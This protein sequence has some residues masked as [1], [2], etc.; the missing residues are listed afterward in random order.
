MLEALD[1]PYVQTLRAMGT[2]MRTIVPRYAVKNAMVPILSV[3]AFQLS[4]LIGA[5]FVVEQVFTVPG[6]GSQLIDAVGRKDIPVVQGITL[7][8]ALVVIGVYFL[9]DIGYALLNPRA[10]PQ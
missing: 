7:V 5:S 9:T 2:P 4:T 6:I 10:R 1:A 3:I 8:V